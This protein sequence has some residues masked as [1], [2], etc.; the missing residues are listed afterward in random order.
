M[1]DSKKCPNRLHISNIN[2]NT[3][4][5][6][7]RCMPFKTQKSTPEKECLRHWLRTIAYRPD[8]ETYIILVIFQKFSFSYVGYS[9]KFFR[10]KILALCR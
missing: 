2:S 3:F 9:G 8:A 10:R 4:I 7:A 6:I 1:T 5:M